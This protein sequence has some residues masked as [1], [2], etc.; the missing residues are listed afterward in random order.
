MKL[1]ELSQKPKLIK[2]TIKEEKLVEKYGD[3]LDFYVYDRQPINVFTSL[4]S[5][6]EENIGEMVGLMQEMILDEDGKPVSEEGEVLPMDVVSEAGRLVR[7]TLG[8]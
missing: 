3:E 5:A 8:K 2:L 7:E 6:G 4:A 1:K